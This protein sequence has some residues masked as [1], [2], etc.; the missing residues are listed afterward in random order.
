[1]VMNPGMLS[2]LHNAYETVS[3]RLK[4]V[5]NIYHLD[6]SFKEGKKPDFQ[7]VAYR[8]A[9]RMVDIMREITSQQLLVTDRITMGR[10]EQDEGRIAEILRKIVTDPKFLP[11]E[12]AEKSNTEQ[13]IVPYALLEDGEG[14]FFSAVRR[15]DHPREALRGKRTLLVGGHAEKKDWD[16]RNPGNIYEACLKRELEEELIGIKIDGIERLGI[17]SDDRTSVGQKHLAILFKVKVGHS[18]KIRRQATDQ[19]F[20]RE[21]VAWITREDIGTDINNL[22]PWSQ[23]VAAEYF[24]AQLPALPDEPTL[25][26]RNGRQD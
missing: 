19:E 7:M 21:P 8:V 11:R 4:S 18:V 2:A 5:F 26:T 25:F 12:K 6:T 22:D 13:Q 23:L 20:G 17:I 3:G 24:G 16:S 1:L 14:K 15:K 10:V 9:T